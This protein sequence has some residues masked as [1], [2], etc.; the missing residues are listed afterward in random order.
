MLRETVISGGSSV[1]V[2]RLVLRDVAD[3]TDVARC[4]AAA[5]AAGHSC[6]APTQI[7]ERHQ[8]STINHQ[9]T[10]CVGY[11]S[12]GAVTVMTGWLHDDRVSAEEARDIVQQLEHI[13]RETGATYVI[14]PCTKDCRMLDHLKD[15]GWR[16]L[17]DYHLFMKRLSPKPYHQH[18]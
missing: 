9:P 1:P 11:A 6:A 10:D 13:A 12:I 4:Q 18:D 17:P 2:S 3:A 7:I 16:K 8:P 5:R 14:M 15:I